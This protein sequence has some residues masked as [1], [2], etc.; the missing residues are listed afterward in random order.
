VKKITN[1]DLLT[2]AGF[3]AGT[4]ACGLRDTPGDDL[5]L[6]VSEGDCA[7]AGV[8]TRNRVAAAPVTLDRQT[9]RDNSAAQRVIVIN[10][11]AANAATGRD[12]DQAARTTQIEA[13]RLFDCRP[14]QVLLMSTGVIGAPLDMSKLVPGL[15]LAKQGLSRSAGPAAAR[16]IMTTDTRPKYLAVE[17][18]LAGGAV[19]I[20]GMAKGSGM[21]HPDMATM[22]A[23]LTTDAE[24]PP[25]SLQQCLE[26]AID[27]S[28]HRISVD[29]DTSTND[30]VI[31][32][33]NGASQVPVSSD[34]LPRF[35]AALTAVCVDLAQAI[36]RDGEGASKFVH[37]IVEGALSEADAVRVGRV[38][39][40]SPLVKTALAG[41]DP[42][43]GRILAA[44]G[45][46][47]VDFQPDAVSLWIGEGTAADVP[48]VEQGTPVPHS[49]AEA[50]AVMGG[51]E[52]AIRLDLG[53][54]TAEAVVWTCD[55]THD[56][57]S[58]NA[59]YHT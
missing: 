36:V 28:F 25:A 54:G 14:D 37:L 21:I 22:L 20:G 17:V 24:I 8:F 32:L 3:L 29:G 23:V 45:R 52:F 59:D 55:L 42:N 43:W 18:E 1:G 57:V 26:V 13:A 33:A 4:S 30:S 53:A 15:A 49:L 31:V 40:T 39:A 5:A 16:A 10:A 58:L 6:V 34:D 46:A 48:L 2:P 50:A 27:H 9:L 51:D 47:G 44:A 41:G 7:A 35:E 19:R 11:G 12:G 38:V 56:Y